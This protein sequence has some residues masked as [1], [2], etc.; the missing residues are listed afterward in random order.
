MRKERGRIPPD[1][2][3]QPENSTEEF[4]RAAHYHG[5]EESARAYRRIQEEVV[6]G[7]PRTDL[8]SYRLFLEREWYVTAL[9]TKPPEHVIQLIDSILEGGQPVTLPNEALLY[10]RL[11]RLDAEELGPEVQGRF[12]QLK[13]RRRIK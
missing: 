4:V 13:K 5:A 6:F 7:E 12:G 1:K 11:R 10:L 2:T 9:G 3:K 8:S